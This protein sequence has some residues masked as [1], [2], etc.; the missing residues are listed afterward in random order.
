[1][2]HHHTAY[3][4]ACPVHPRLRHQRLGVAGGHRPGAVRGH[5]CLGLGETQRL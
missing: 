2:T 5:S 3:H 1:G 4:L